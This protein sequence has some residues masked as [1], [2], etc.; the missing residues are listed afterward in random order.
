MSTL[1]GSKQLICTNG[2]SFPFPSLTLSLLGT[3]FLMA[4]ALKGHALATGP[5][6]E[7]HLLD[8]R[9]ILLGWVEFELLLGLML[10]SGLYPALTRLVASACFAGFLG[11]TL[12]R[13][14]SGQPSCGCFGKW[15]VN[16][17]YVLAFDLAA[18]VALLRW[19]SA[20]GQAPTAR[21]HPA[22]F[23][24]LLALFLAAGVPGAVVMGN[25][26]PATLADGGDIIGDSRVVVLDPDAWE[27]RRWPLLRHIDI[28]NE[29]GRG[30]WRV[31]L[32]HQDCRLCQ[33]AVVKFEEL[34]LDRANDPGAARVALIEVP[35]PDGAWPG[36]RPD[37][38]GC[39]CGRLSPTR[40]W[41][42]QTPVALK[43]HDGI[44]AR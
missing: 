17:W 14:F 30:R 44:V 20:Q 31:L 36:A 8:S 38:S 32:Y 40:E 5:V 42:V 1:T 33:E 27:G 18:L 37:H 3:V 25:F 9:W 28:G 39:R 29:L 19:K 16:P 4:G 15:T 12:A 24:G 2:K 41:F 26:T 10:L 13:A 34:A 7:T 23:A 6:S 43:L 11:F 22:R 35:A 21:S